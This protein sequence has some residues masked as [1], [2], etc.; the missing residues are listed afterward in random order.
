M[1]TATL[2]RRAALALGV[3]LLAACGLARAQK[4]TATPL[5][6]L[7]TPAR[8]P[9]P[10]ATQ[11]ALAAAR[12]ATGAAG[13][14]AAA[15]SSPV[16]TTATPAAPGTPTSPR[17]SAVAASPGAPDYTVRDPT[18]S[19]QLTLPGTFRSDGVAWRVDAE[20]VATLAGAPTGGFVDF[21]TAAGLLAGNLRSVITDYQETGRA[22]DGPDRLRVTFTGKILGVPG[23]GILYQRGFGQT[24]CG[25]VL[26]AA[27]GQQARY[28]GT[29]E[30][31]I[32][33][34]AVA[35]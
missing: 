4:P 29:F 19:C 27:E 32:A 24:V 1:T 5:D 26:L 35:R 15:R 31:I 12:A 14:T 30:R 22:G 18:G 33:S 13:Q 17:A 10:P 21:N 6:V 25:V 9:L 8:T 23:S 34:L 20:A 11:T 3:W 28:G 7:V 2:R 16:G